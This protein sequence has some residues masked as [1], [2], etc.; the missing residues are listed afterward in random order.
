M[1]P[2]RGPTIFDRQMS[3]FIH[4]KGSKS[5][6]KKSAAQTKL[7]IKLQAQHEKKEEEKKLAE[8][9]KKHLNRTPIKAEVPIIASL[10]TSLQRKQSA[11]SLKKSG[12]ESSDSEG[13][14][15]LQE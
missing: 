9:S 2:I 7:K 14:K 15:A 12:Y 5:G 10:T 1:I 3:E 13:T 6:N 4:G 11:K 8:A